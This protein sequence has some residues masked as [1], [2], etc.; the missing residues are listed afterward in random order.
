MSPTDKYSFGANVIAQLGEHVLEFP[1]PDISL[2]VLAAA[3]NDLRLKLQAAIGGDKTCILERNEAEK[4][5]DSLFRKTGQYVERIAGGNKLLITQGGYYSVVTE[6]QRQARPESP[7]LQ[8]WGNKVK[9]SIHAQI[10]PL[11]SARGLVF[12]A[13]TLPMAELSIR[14]SKGQ[15]AI[16]AKADAHVVFI[17]GTKRKVNFEGLHTGQPYYV[18]AFA[19]NAAGMGDITHTIDVT[20]P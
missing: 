9:G 19:F 6:V 5:W 13:S 18:A 14:M 11:T 12:I 8:A 4:Q 16:V 7:S 20:A 10:R 2:P 3:N 1:T 17:M 15:L